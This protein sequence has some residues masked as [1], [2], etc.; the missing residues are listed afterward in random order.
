MANIKLLCTYQKINTYVN[1][2]A[3]DKEGDK[4]GKDENKA[5]ESTPMEVE[6]SSDDKT[7]SEEEKTT[8]DDQ[9]K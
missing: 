1:I 8:T 4:E 9:G 2:L 7:A 5:E 6:Q 3:K